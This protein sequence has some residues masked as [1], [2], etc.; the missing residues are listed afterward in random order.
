MPLLAG[1]EGGA[2]DDQMGQQGPAP[3]VVDPQPAPVVAPTYVPPYGVAPYANGC[4][5]SYARGGNKKV[6][7]KIKRARCRTA[8]LRC[9]YTDACG[10]YHRHGH[11]HDHGYGAGYGDRGYNG[12]GGCC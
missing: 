7:I 3:I 10:R 11:G 12:N 8:R 9:G 4:D 5:G 2:P 1:Q 6:K